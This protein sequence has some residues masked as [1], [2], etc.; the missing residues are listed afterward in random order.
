MLKHRPNFKLSGFSLIELMIGIAVMVVVVALGIPSYRVWIQ[1]TRIRTA[2]ESIQSGIQIARA[3]AVK[4]NARVQFVLADTHSG[5][6]LGCE[7]PVADNNGDG[8]AD[9]PAVIQSRAASEGSSADTTVTATPADND[10]IVFTSLGVIDSA[11]SPF[12]QLDISSTALSVTDS[13]PLRVTI[14]VGG[15]VRMC[16]PSSTLSASD[17]RKC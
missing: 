17:P 3:E 16:D 7:T 4:R 10:T 1:N 8:V 15:N 5:W 9:C 6:T 12:T 14:G 11:L 2:T 13:R